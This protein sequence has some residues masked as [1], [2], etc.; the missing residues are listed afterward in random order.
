LRLTAAS[1]NDRNEPVTEV[2][3]I[4]A[5][6]SRPASLRTWRVAPRA[7][8]LAIAALLV[9]IALKSWE[10]IHFPEWLSRTD[11]V[12]QYLTWWGYLGRQL[13]EGDI[14]G[15]NPYQFGGTPFL[16]DPQSGWMY[17]PVMIPFTLLS[18]LTAIK[19]Y[20]ALHLLIGGLSMYAFARVIAFGP[21]AAFTAA[22]AFIFGPLIQHTTY[23]CNIQA[24]AATW[25]PLALLGIE[26]ALR[27]RRWSG[28]IAGWGATAFAISQ[29][30]AGWIGQGGYNSLLLIM[31]YLA[32][33]VVLAPTVPGMPWM[34]RFRRLA[35]HG[36]AILVIGFGLAAAAT[37]PRLEVIEETNLAGGRYE[38][39]ENVDAKRG[40][41]VNS[42]VAGMLSPG[43]R[44]RRTT[45][46]AVTAALA[47][48]G[49]IVGRRRPP[50]P[51]FAIQT[52]VVLALAHDTTP[53]H[54]LFYLLPRY[55]EIHQHSYSRV[56]AFLMIGPAVL[57][58]AAIQALP[59]LSPRWR[60]AA[61][62]SPLVGISILSVGLESNQQWI[63]SLDQPT[64][65]AVVAVSVL[66][67]V[68]AFVRSR[69][70]ELHRLAPLCNAA[71]ILI[72]AALLWEPSGR[73]LVDQLRN[74]P[75]HPRTMSIVETNMSRT[76]FGSAGDFLQLRLSQSSEPF[77]YIGYDGIDLRTEGNPL[78]TVYHNRFFSPPYRRL[79]I[80]PRSVWLELYH[81]QGYNP[82]QLKRTVELFK[83]ISG[84]RLEYHDAYVLPQ[85]MSSP[86]IDVYAVRYFIV[87]AT[88]PPGRPDLL[89]LNQ[90]HPPALDNGEVRVLRNTDALPYAW[91][92][93][94]ARSGPDS[95]AISQIEFGMLDPQEIAVL[96]PSD[97]L[98]QLEAPADPGAESVTVT[99]YEA[100]RIRLNARLESPGIVVLSETYDPAW[101]VSVDGSSARLI[102]VDGVLRGVFLPAGEHSVELRYAPRSIPLGIAISAATALCLLLG[103]ALARRRAFDH[104][105]GWFW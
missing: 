88:V 93:H 7:D 48:F 34:A 63:V 64:M 91:I 58:G 74:S 26:I 62:F 10:R 42:L 103:I 38:N 95:E 13:G 32:Y 17:L 6:Q 102:A 18:P 20:V 22:A 72:V 70:N 60:F 96:E 97:S 12:N 52:L 27:S 66:L 46:G 25:L 43:F 57:A 29:I 1:W 33:R 75:V 16:G 59:S 47:I 105:S 76:D 85:G 73:D 40:A 45:L 100:D 19:L 2:V 49:A 24:H 15:W 41:T 39:V 23:C 86:W 3:D 104:R 36:A 44:S 4:E 68:F 78:G 56:L 37:L 98:P 94:E 71:P 65:Q 11:V 89:H 28:R 53:L 31:A 61:I 8:L 80:G 9:F 55:Q 51:F 84:Q 67:A 101:K 5:P 90:L 21:L 79:L 92:V 54:R 81:L 50:I 35:V 77:R 14:P 87:P 82:V 69:S 30:L 99:G 83:T